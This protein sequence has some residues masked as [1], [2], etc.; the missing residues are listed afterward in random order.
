M[1]YTLQILKIESRYYIEPW[2]S[3]TRKTHKLHFFIPFVIR[4]IENQ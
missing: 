1:Q 3:I 4:V 2:S